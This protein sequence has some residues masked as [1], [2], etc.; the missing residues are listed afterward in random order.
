[1]RELRQSFAEWAGDTAWEDSVS[2]IV[3][4]P[5]RDPTDVDAY[6]RWQDQ[7][8]IGGAQ[9]LSKPIEICDYDPAWPVLYVREESLVRSILGERVVRVE[10]V[11]STSVPGLC[12]K[13]I[14][15]VVLEVVDSAVEE[16]YLPDLEAGGYFLH[17]R[18]PDWFEHRQFKCSDRDVHLHVFS[19][20]CEEV[21]AMLR[22]RD[23]LRVNS[24]DRELYAAA[25]RE[26][27]ARAWKYGQQYADAKSPVIREIMARADRSPET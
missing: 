24:A 14:I 10:H 1:M 5:P 26:L 8:T 9:P 23:H 3:V 13:P 12:A 18:E 2:L 6:D 15:D 22:F 7:I 19:A 20:G 17:V 16:A 21:G 11:G 25:K 4:G 27:A